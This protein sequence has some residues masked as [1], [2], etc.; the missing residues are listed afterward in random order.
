MFPPGRSGIPEWGALNRLHR[1]NPIRP[2][3][4]DHYGRQLASTGITPDA[5]AR[6][7]AP[8]FLLLIG[9]VHRL[10]CHGCELIES[11]GDLPALDEN[12]AA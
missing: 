3:A 8:I 5:G 7:E 11:Q 1:G 12:R 9:G 2:Q 10:F 6:H 4:V